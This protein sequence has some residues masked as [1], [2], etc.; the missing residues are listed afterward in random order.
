MFLLF[1][2]QKELQIAYNNNNK[3][4]MTDELGDMF[5]SLVNFARWAKIDPEEAMNKATEKELS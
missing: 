2:E 1:E 4:E 3:E 5:F